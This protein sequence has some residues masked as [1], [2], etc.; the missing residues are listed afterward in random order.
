MHD[1][2]SLYIAV[3]INVTLV[4]THTHKT[5]HTLPGSVRTLH[6]ITVIKHSRVA[7]F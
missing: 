1:Y 4:N 7:V 5:F 3:I 6:I 2:K